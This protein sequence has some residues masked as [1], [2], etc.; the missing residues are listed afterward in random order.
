MLVLWEGYLGGQQSLGLVGER[1]VLALRELGVDVLVHCWNTSKVH[2]RTAFP[3]DADARAAGYAWGNAALAHMADATRK[4][5]AQSPLVLS[6]QEQA[7]ALDIVGG[8]AQQLPY[9]HWRGAGKYGAYIYCDYT[10]ISGDEV[11]VLNRYASI[12]LVPSLFCRDVLVNSGVS[13]PVVVWSHG[14]DPAIHFPLQGEQNRRPFTFLWVGV[15]QKRKG[16]EELLSAFSAAF[17]EHDTDVRLV[18]KSSDWGSV[19]DWQYRY[20]HSRI[21]WIHRNYSPR[22]MADLYRQS[23][24]LVQPTRAD[25][26]CLPALEAGACGLPVIVTKFGGALDFC[27]EDT[28]YLLNVERLLPVRHPL[29][30]RLQG[31]R[32]TPKWAIPDVQHLVHLMRQVRSHPD[33]ARE[34][35]GRAAKKLAEWTWRSRTEAVLPELVAVMES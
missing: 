32:D 15:A 4:L 2:K 31:Y 14:I 1:S 26:F 27:T 35:G 7:R 9:A 23:D 29:N 22:E 18:A 6:W 17:S 30:S 13:V 8:W 5:V 25:A 24:C 16:I 34:R 28:A 3:R 11:L 12:V 33:E 21:E 20:P 19:R 10:S